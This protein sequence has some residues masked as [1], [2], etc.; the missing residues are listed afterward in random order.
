MVG[1]VHVGARA[2]DGRGEKGAGAPTRDV[3]GR[4]EKGEGKRKLQRGAILCLMN[5][6]ARC[7]HLSSRV[8][9]NPP[10]PPFSVCA[11]HDLCFYLGE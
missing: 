9:S 3:R 8:F 5:A 6:V 2:K 4:A 11:A 1:V 10:S 7:S